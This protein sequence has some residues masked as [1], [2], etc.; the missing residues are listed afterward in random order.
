MPCGVEQTPSL[1]LSPRQ[2]QVARWIAEANASPSQRSDSFYGVVVRETYGV[3]GHAGTTR[4][5]G[6]VTH[7]V[8]IRTIVELIPGER[9]ENLGSRRS[10]G[11]V[12]SV[13][14]IC[15]SARVASRLPE[16]TP[17]TCR[18]CGGER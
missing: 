3:G 15:R 18:L 4:R 14:P 8:R 7:M 16:T 6:S 1:S 11:T 12:L 9:P 2:R 10:V 13:E 17:V 5:T